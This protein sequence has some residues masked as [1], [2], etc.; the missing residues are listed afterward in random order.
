MCLEWAR[1]EFKMNWLLN[2]NESEEEEWGATNIGQDL[3][4]K[5][6]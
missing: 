2:S 5:K 1:K 3:F 4:V 6:N